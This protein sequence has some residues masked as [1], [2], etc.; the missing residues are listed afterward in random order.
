MVI[1][2][3]D[4][5][6]TIGAPIAKW[7]FLISL[8]DIFKMVY[9]EI[10]DNEL[11][12]WMNGSLLYKRW[13]NQGHGVVFCSVFGPFRPKFDPSTSIKISKP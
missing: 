10:K 6:R 3:L 12:V 13:I 4:V 5:I 2:I 8:I 11:Y 9:K 7:K 1:T